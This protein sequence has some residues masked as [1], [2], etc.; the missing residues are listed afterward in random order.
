M[1]M[2][3]RLRIAPGLLCY[4]I[5]FASNVES[6]SQSTTQVV[7]TCPYRT[8]NYITHSLPQQCH[9]SSWSS[10]PATSVDESNGST[11]VAVTLTA[12]VSK[13]AAAD[14]SVT[15]TSE[16]SHSPSK[17]AHSSATSSES[18]QVT[19]TPS[20]EEDDS[21]S[22]SALG[23]ANFLS[24]E[25]W[26]GQN[27]AKLGQSAEHIGKKQP[28]SDENRKRP[29]N[30]H[31]S[32]D[33]L[34]DDA[35]IDLDFGGFAAQKPETP[36]TVELRR[37]I[38][39]PSE[40]EV[41]DAD[42]TPKAK[43]RNKDAGTTCKE[44]FN[45]ASFDCA[46]AVRKTNPQ[47]SGATSV[48][49]EKNR[50]SYMLNECG[51]ENKF[52]I[53]ELCDDIAIDT[54]VLANFEFF[55]STFRTFRVSVSDRYPVKVDKWKVLGTYEARNTREIQAFLVENPVIWARYLRIEFLTHYG[56]EFYCP[57]SLIR[58]H[59]TT[60]MEDYK[61]D[62][63]ASRAEDEAEQEDE[64][65]L[66]VDV[67]E[68][69]DP[70]AVAQPI[71]DEQASRTSSVESQK[72][73]YTTSPSDIPSIS[74]GVYSTQTLHVYPTSPYVIAGNLGNDSMS[75]IFESPESTCAIGHSPT[76]LSVAT[77]FISDSSSDRITSTAPG[78]YASERSGTI[79]SSS[80][81][82][83]SS[84]EE[85]A[86]SSD[87][88]STNNTTISPSKTSSSTK[89]S[90]S[91]HSKSST[92]THPHSANPTIQE[93]FFK[94]VQKRLQMLESNSSL[95]LQYI[96]EQSR[97]LR[98]AFSKVEH[99]QVAKTTTFLDY[100]NTTVLN[101]LKDFRQQYDQI[102]QSTVI[103]LE[104]QR[105]QYQRE[106]LAMNARLGILA[107]EVIFQKR[108]SIL[109]STLVLLCLALVLFS[110]GALNTYLELPIVQN[111]MARSPS[112][113]TTLSPETPVSSP[114]VERRRS[115]L[116]G[117]S[118]GSHDDREDASHEGLQRVTSPEIA[119]SPPTPTSQYD[120]ESEADQTDSEVE[121]PSNSI[122]D[123]S[124]IE[125]PSSSPGILIRTDDTPSPQT[126]ALNGDAVRPIPQMEPLDDDQ[127]DNDFSNGRQL[128]DIPE[129]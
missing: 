106:V 105:E 68:K 40:E 92:A 126:N 6:A 84:P 41:L 110:R 103:E 55:S 7:S 97:I 16:T 62:E 123:L 89:I 54:V 44:R 99:K 88:N 91:D 35:E 129:T 100:L 96:E 66:A 61:H 112:W 45:Y 74:E 63:E 31:N 26:K 36:D 1:K 77:A 15:S 10:A 12:T 107:D 83:T 32:L 118:I 38:D 113:R 78:Q 108:M 87:T 124:P 5:A 34:G 58:V 14:T 69:L 119:Y 122:A 76:V 30:I 56:S 59:G 13:S 28:L 25:E 72:E 90:H 19:N 17:D 125:R 67:G 85:Q 21:D 11:D 73:T 120:A 48:L 86:S 46:A 51:A 52:I 65:T 116:R 75:M 49:I 70:D 81:M 43:L 93:S 22:D 114:S 79:V 94:S 9:K 95:S 109:Q 71:L 53:L 98:E 60:M 101:E 82:S 39:T 23:N 115:S 33:S 29:S 2:K 18:L 127:I 80:S 50:D 64:A 4:F 8:V 111:V 57:V 117:K 47:A 42:S 37:A 128:V 102:W 121:E 20:S 3:A 27:L 24:F 104:T